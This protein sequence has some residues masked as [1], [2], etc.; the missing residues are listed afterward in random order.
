[1]LNSLPRCTA[2]VIL[3]LVRDNTPVA[4]LVEHIPPRDLSIVGFIPC[5]GYH[6]SSLI[7]TAPYRATKNCVQIGEF[8][9]ITEGLLAK[10]VQTQ[11]IRHTINLNRET[12]RYFLWLRLFS[13]F[14]NAI[15]HKSCSTDR[16]CG[17]A[18]SC[19]C[20]QVL[21]LPNIFTADPCEIEAA[22]QD[23]SPKRSHPLNSIRLIIAQVLCQLRGYFCNDVDITQVFVNPCYQYQSATIHQSHPRL[24][25][26][27]AFGS[28]TGI[29][30]QKGHKQVI[31]GDLHH[32]I[33]PP[34][35]S[36]RRRIFLQDS[37]T[38]FSLI[39]LQ[40]AAIIPDIFNK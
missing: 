35:S 38:V 17:L 30:L 4:T 28:K 34:D 13:L 33:H 20:S 5:Q 1:M 36:S 25:L 8:V 39:P 23:E 21:Q 14:L 15:S 9:R 11:V 12:I 18:S 37:R 10:Q 27:Q 3:Q 31:V 26:A 40:L 6:G 16:L 2:N 32:Q 24:S 22:V 7:Q 29:L 19:N